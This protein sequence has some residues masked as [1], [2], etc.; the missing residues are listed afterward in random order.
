[1]K[2][3][4]SMAFAHIH[5]AWGAVLWTGFFLVLTACNNK[6]NFAVAD[7][8]SPATF[9]LVTSTILQPLCSRC[10]SPSIL[11]GGVVLTTYDSLMGSPG[12]VIP[13]QPYQSNIFKQCY[14]EYMPQGG[15][16]LSSA[17]LTLIYDW[18][19]NGALNN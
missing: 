8:A 18:I 12:A 6:P 10:H 3:S 2:R 15:P 5:I 11:N 16:P 4:E 13:Y 1:M 7:S 19:A 9:P 14:L 17:Q